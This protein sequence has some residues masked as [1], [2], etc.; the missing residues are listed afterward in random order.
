VELTVFPRGNHTPSTKILTFSRN[1]TFD[2]EAVYADP[3]LLPGQI[4]PW[5]GKV[6]VKDPSPTGE[7]VTVKVKT[8]LN[9]NGLVSFE[10][11]YAQDEVEEDL[12]PP[13]E[14][15]EPKKRKVTKRNLAVVTSTLASDSAVVAELREVENNMHAGDKLVTDTEDRKNALEEYV[16]DMR[17]KLDG[18]YSNFVQSAEKEKLM[19]ALNEAENWLYS[20]EGEDATKSAYVARLDTL[21]ALGNPIALRF[22]EADVRPR[23]ISKLR[24]TI[25]TF[26]SQATS[27]DERWDH[28]DQKDKDSVIEKAANVQKWL[29]DQVARQAERPLNVNPVLTED[30]V[31]K[32]RQELIFFATPIFSK[33]KPKP[34]VDTP[35]PPPPTN[36]TGTPSG[37]GTE[38]PAENPTEPSEMDVD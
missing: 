12:A 3:S 26:L 20:E 21:L 1:S 27:I 19:A 8:R 4:N 23:V 33:L 11:A 2:L 35:P 14:G 6:T 30:E 38:T 17:S 7:L 22:N 29:D 31:E 24:E 25:N 34:K 32:K 13:A 37:T 36:G 28:I 5:I 9:A 16:Y 10:G 15:E 18:R